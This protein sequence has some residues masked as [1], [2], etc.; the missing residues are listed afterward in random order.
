MPPVV[1]HAANTNDTMHASC[2]MHVPSSWPSLDK[3]YVPEN[4]SMPA[5]HVSQMTSTKI[6]CI[7]FS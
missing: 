1:T 2:D 4:S 6:N 7:A 5:I 3:Y